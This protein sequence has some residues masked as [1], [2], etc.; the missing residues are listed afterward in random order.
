MKRRAIWNQKGIA[1]VTALILTLAIMAMATGV[2]YFI[3]YAVSLSG[4]GKKYATE[5]EA[6]DGAADLMKEAINQIPDGNAAPTGLGAVCQNNA[7]L[8]LTSALINVN[9]PCVVSVALPGTMGG[10][11]TATITVTRLYTK[12][13]AG[14]RI[15][16]ARGGGGGAPS[17]AVYYRITTLVSSSNDNS[18]A[19]N[20]T[21]YQLA[22]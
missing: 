15:E 22:R 21:L 3:N 19:E 14:G 4:A 16:F 7:A 18:K 10:S 13:L 2:L 6:A 9:Q 8:S 5:A 17:S 1:L 20:T 11:Y 12:G